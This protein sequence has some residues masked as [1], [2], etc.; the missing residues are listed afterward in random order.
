MNYKLYEVGGAVRDSIIGVVSKDID[1]T[2]VI[3]DITL[4]PSIAF[5]WFI[6][7]IKTQGYDIFLISPSVFT[8]R[9][10]FP[11]THKF[12]G[13]VADF[14]LARKESGHQQGTRQPETCV[15]GTLL[16]DLTRRDFT[17]NAIARCIETGEIIDPFNGTHD[18]YHKVL[19]C[20]IDATTSFNDDPLRMLRAIRFAVTK[21]F[22]MSHEILEAIAACNVHRFQETV[23]VERIYEELNKMFTY[24][25]LQTLCYMNWLEYYNHDLYVYIFNNITLVPKINVN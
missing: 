7:D 14:V 3:E 1:Y 2:V 21:K 4:S 18:I 23:S 8:V 9:A 6:D 22:T 11:K 13:L 10:K 17:V 25:T 20:P 16:D 15:L 19:N 12:T 5:E 24:D